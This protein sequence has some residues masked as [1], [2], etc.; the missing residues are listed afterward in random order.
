MADGS[1][2][3]RRF[4]QVSTTSSNG[5]PLKNRFDPLLT[6]TGN[7]KEN[8][9]N[10]MDVD[11]TQRQTGTTA[12]NAGIVTRNS[13]KPPPVIV[14]GTLSDGNTAIQALKGVLK[15]RFQYK[16][17]NG[18]TSFY[19]NNEDDHKKLIEYLTAKQFQ[20]HTFTLSS[21]KLI[22]LI[23][24]GLPPS[25]TADDI[26]E[27]LKE[28]QF[29]VEKI[30]QIS[31]KQEYPLYSVLFSPGTNTQEVVKI[32]TLCYCIVSWE[33]PHKKVNPTQCY[34]C[35]KFHHIANNCTRKLKCRKCAGDHH[36]KDC[37]KEDEE[38][39]CANCNQKHPANS[40]DC[41][42]YI[43]VSERRR[44]VQSIPHQHH[45]SQPSSRI[46]SQTLL[47]QRH[48]WPQLRP[49]TSSMM[50]SSLSQPP[51]NPAP[52]PTRNPHMG[53]Q[54]TG[55]FGFGNILQELKSLFSGFNFTKILT[56]AK[57]VITKIKRAPDGFSKFTIVLDSICEFFDD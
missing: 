32:K 41:E 47:T 45:T 50:N 52:A 29:N 39:E 18:K 25:I 49:T 27:E 51:P 34:K 54:E 12:Q 38:S 43:K 40:K 28:L 19:T 1:G 55:S 11:P 31:Q 53:N 22:K 44:N 33:K 7:D 3:K 15:D 48:H 8:D 30:N 6:N 5:I 2:N 20:F 42:I 35:Q 23:L 56:F 57:S 26:K 46:A 9:L 4:S 10:G 36:I 21:E 24:K 16:Y 37:E 17:T 14:D 13:K